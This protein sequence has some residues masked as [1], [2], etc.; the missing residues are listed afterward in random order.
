MATIIPK[1][2][3]SGEIRSY[4]IRVCLGR[5]ENYKQIFRNT[6]ISRPEGLTPA[7]ERKEVERL[8]DEWE[9]NQREEYERTKS[10]TDKTKITFADFV[11]NHW[12]ADHVMDGE[13]TPNSIAFYRNMSNHLV[14]YFGNKKLNAIDAE[15]VKRYIKYL[16]TTATTKSG[17]PL[18]A[19]TKQHL[20]G[21][22]RNIMEYARRFH[23]IQSDPCQDLSQKEK[24]HREKKKVDFLDTTDAR[25]F[26]Q[27]LESE[28]LYWRTF[29][30]LVITTGLRRG[31]ALGLQWADLDPEKMQATVERSVSMDK[32]S[33]SKIYIGSTKTKEA[34]QVPISPRLY[35][36]LKALKSERENELGAKL[37]PSAFIFSAPADP[38]K[39]CFPTEPTRQMRKIVKKYKLPNVSPHDLRHTAATLALESGADLKQVQ[40]LLGHSDAKTT[41]EFYA[42]VSEESQRRTVEGIESLI[43]AN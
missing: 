28:P 20:F 38:Y 16:N 23:Y 7:K 8:A 33:E 25:R 2:G 31:E 32:D 11:K 43:T 29:F 24:P 13:H 21:T 36:L 19:T 17:K 42:G 14:D 4:M 35:S 30:N 5:D 22:L 37:L 26:L 40:M 39:P 12:W 27:C 34:R 3:K 9:R 41:L 6:T 10:K 15:A 1:K 18:S